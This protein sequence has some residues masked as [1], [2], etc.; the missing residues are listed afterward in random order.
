M[1][2]PLVKLDM[3][4]TIAENSP[5]APLAN[6]VHSSRIRSSYSE[7]TEEAPGAGKQQVFSI[8]VVF[9]Q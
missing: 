1:Q 9:S 5:I 3:I 2:E 4:H 8:T 6:A 7:L